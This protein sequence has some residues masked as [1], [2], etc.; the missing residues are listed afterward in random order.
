MAPVIMVKGKIITSQQITGFQTSASNLQ[1]NISVWANAGTIQLYKGNSNWLNDMF[2]LEAFRL[3]SGKLSAFGKSVLAYIKAHAPLVKFN[4]AKGKASRAGNKDNRLYSVFVI[5]GLMEADEVYE[6]DVPTI[7]IKPIL[8][9]NGEPVKDEAG[10]AQFEPDFDFTYTFSEFLNLDKA[11]KAPSTAPL[12]ATTVSGQLKKVLEALENKKF[13]ASAG[14]V[15]KLAG[16]LADLYALVYTFAA[17]LDGALPALD[18]DMANRLAASGQKGKSAKAGDKVEGPVSDAKVTLTAKEKR[19]IAK[20]KKVQ[21]A[22]ADANAN[23]QAERDAK[24]AEE[25]PQ[26]AMQAIA[27]TALTMEMADKAKESD[28]ADVQPFKKVS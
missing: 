12:K 14:E 8:D 4:E 21:A 5:P 18:V 10:I 9:D 1:A 23:I 2:Q 19:A 17:Q 6:K 7:A 28:G 20:G 3:K 26:K 24:A 27:E 22:D 16:E 25:A 15:A 13:S 11:P